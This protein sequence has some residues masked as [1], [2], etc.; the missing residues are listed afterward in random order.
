MLLKQDRGGAVQS[1]NVGC[2]RRTP[3]GL[4]MFIKGR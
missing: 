3:E 2:S 4:E 1:T